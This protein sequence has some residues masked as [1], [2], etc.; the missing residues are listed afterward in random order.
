[1]ALA[2][3]HVVGS[4]FSI[5]TRLNEA[6]TGIEDVHVIPYVIDSGPAKGQRRSVK[7][8]ESQYNLDG[9]RTAIESDLNTTHQIAQLGGGG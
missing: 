2:A 5:E 6:G 8:P 1:M 7:V 9:V 3:Y 4:A